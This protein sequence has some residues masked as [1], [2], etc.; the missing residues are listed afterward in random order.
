MVN[1]IRIQADRSNAYNCDTYTLHK[2][3]TFIIDIMQENDETIKS[4]IN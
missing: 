3:S 1:E 2:H 4:Y